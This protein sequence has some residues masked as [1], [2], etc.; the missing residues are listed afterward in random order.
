[1][2]RPR[3]E[4]LDYFPMDIVFD[5]KVGY[6]E[7]LYGADGIYI[8]L[9]LLQRIYAKG[10]FLEWDKIVKVNLKKESEGVSIDRIQ[11]IVEECVAIGLFDEMLFKEQHILTSRGIQ[12]RFFEVAKRR[13]EVVIVEEYIVFDKMREHFCEVSATETPQKPND[14]EGLCNQSEEETQQKP[15]E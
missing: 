8:W 1:M 3:K 7:G 9:K 2:A 12:K 4:G 15:E 11:M 6:I 13:E 10:Y 14:N 5:D